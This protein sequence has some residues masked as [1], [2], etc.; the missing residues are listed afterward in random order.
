MVTYGLVVLST[1]IN[2]LFIAVGLYQEVHHSV[3]GQ[4]AP[5]FAKEGW[6]G[7]D[8]ELVLFTM[9]AAVWMAPFLEEIA[10]RLF[11]R[12]RVRYLLASL[13]LQ[14]L[15]FLNLLH[16]PK[17]HPLLM[18]AAGLLIALIG[19][20]GM[21]LVKQ[22]E[23]QAQLARWWRGH[24]SLIYYYSAITFGLV[25]YAAYGLQGTARWFAP[26]ILAPIII[27]GLMLGL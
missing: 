27:M 21:L 6:S 7:P 11:L 16:I 2:E 23:Y 10:F 19:T 5:V 22:P 14:V 18:V 1:L 13:A 26:I 9:V 15:F 17:N 25:H 4:L 8:W 12:Y 24:F 20:V 3:I